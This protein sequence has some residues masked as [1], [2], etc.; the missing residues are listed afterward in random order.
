[1]VN[2]LGRF[3]WYELITTDTEAAKA[4]YADVMGWGVGEVSTPSATYSVFSVGDNSVSGLMELPKDAKNIGA[5]P[6]WIGYVRVDNVNAADDRVKRLGGTVYAPPTDIPNFGRFSVVAD[7]QMAT[8]GLLEC[9]LSSQ[10]RHIDP[11]TLGRV[12]WHELLALDWSKALTFYGELF[13]WQ[14]AEANVGALGT[15]Q[16][17][18]VGGETIGGMA[19]KPR[20]VPVAFWL[21]YFSIGDIDAAV[22]RVKAGG[23]KILDGPVEVLDGSWIAHCA[24]PQ[25]AIFALVGKRNYKARV[26]LQSAASHE[27]FIWRKHS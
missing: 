18:S 5:K 9:S 22:K 4:F 11:D 23:G 3:L 20:R 13:G 27:V 16:R 26:F 24:D 17:F 10:E 12:R 2:S 25:G 6:Y 19:T 21:Y 15:Y 8:L 7:L 14:K 1:V